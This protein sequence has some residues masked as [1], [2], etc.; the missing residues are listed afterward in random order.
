MFRTPDFIYSQRN[1]FLVRNFTYNF[2]EVR[3]T[4]PATRIEGVPRQR[5]VGR[6]AV[7][8]LPFDEIGRSPVRVAVVR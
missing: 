6:D 8:E 3:A 5:G 7:L 4:H 1:I 2:W